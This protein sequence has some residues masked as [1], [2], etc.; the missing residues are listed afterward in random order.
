MEGPATSTF[1]A[2]AVHLMVACTPAPAWGL[3]RRSARWGRGRRA[4]GRLLGHR[5]QDEGLLA[6]EEDALSRRYSSR[7]AS[8]MP[9]RCAAARSGTPRAVAGGAVHGT[10]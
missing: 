1:T 5:R 7:G 9:C 8:P 2:S 4:S 6:A 3:S 10:D